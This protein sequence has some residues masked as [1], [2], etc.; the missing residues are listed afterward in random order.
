MADRYV[1]IDTGNTQT[2]FERAVTQLPDRS[3]MRTA[4]VVI[5]S[6]N[7][8]CLVP[9]YCREML[10]SQTERR[11]VD[12]IIREITMKTP[13]LGGL[14]ADVYAFFVPNRI[15]NDEWKEIFGENEN[16]AWYPQEIDLN[17]LVSGTS[18]NVQ[19]PVGSIADYYGIPTQKPF[20]NRLLA[21]MNDLRFRGYFKIWNEFFRDQNYQAP[22]PLSTE[23]NSRSNVWLAPASQGGLSI[24]QPPLKVNKFHDYFTSV[25]P[26]PQKGAG[27]FISLAQDPIP[28]DT[29]QYVTSFSS[30]RSVQFEAFSGADVPTGLH[31]VRFNIP[32]QNADTGIGTLGADESTGSSSVNMIDFTGSNLVVD[33]SEITAVSISALRE[34][35]AT[36]RFYEQLA[37]VGSRYREYVAG[38]FGIE[39]DNPMRDVP[40]YVGHIRRELEVYQTAQTSASVPGSTP[41]GNLAAFSYTRANGDLFQNGAFTA[42]E[43]GYMHYFVVVRQKNV[44]PSYL[45]PDFF[46]RSMLDFYQPQLANISEQPVYT[47]V[48]NPFASDPEGVFGYQEAWAEYR[49]EPDLVTG[50]MRPGVSGGLSSWNYA[51]EFDSGLTIADDE[52]LLS[53]AEEVVNRTVELTSEASTHQFYAQFVFAGDKEMPMPVYSVPE[54][55]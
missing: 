13:V 14:I 15:I 23:N 46:R 49:D 17:G 38:F 32:V 8:G 30:S 53:N 5:T 31:T 27:V 35:A 44:Y 2:H 3:R 45:A 6:F 47:R 42:L 40:T 29:A 51:D 22:I 52:W 48:I 10:P 34:A 50:L 37:R 9:V 21:Q 39:V 19:I 33:L 18:G 54:L 43:H 28:L 26:S 55:E 36:Q 1:N 12:F 16:G 20:P 7:A 11:S 4:P 24:L 25:L 41:Q